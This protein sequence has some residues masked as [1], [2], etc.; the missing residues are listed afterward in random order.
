MTNIEASRLDDHNGP[1]ALPA[2][3]DLAQETDSLSG[4][5]TRRRLIDDIDHRLNSGDVSQGLALILLDLDRFKAANDSLGPMVCDKLLAKISQ[6]LRIG[7]PA[8]GLIARVSGDGFAILLTQ[9]ADADKVAERLLDL[10]GRPYAVGGHVITLGASLGLATSEAGEAATSALELLHAADLAMHQAEEDGRNR[11]RRF[12]PSMKGRAY[13]RHALEADF[14]AAMALQHVELRHALVSQ[15]FEVHFQPQVRLADNHVAGFEAL[16]RWRHPER[17]LVSPE[18]FIPLAEEIGLI[19]LLGDWVLRTACR[20]ATSWEA[21]N[22]G[23]LLRVAVNVSALQLRDRAVFIAGL[24]RA[25]QESGLAAHRLELELT[26]SLFADDIVDTM[27]AIRDLGVELAL[28]DFGTGYSS[29]GRLRRLP[30]DRLK[31]DRSFVLDLDSPETESGLRS[32]EWMVRAIASLGLPTVCEGVE[33]RAQREIVQRAGCTEI[34]GYLVSR[35][36]A[37]LGVATF[38][39]THDPLET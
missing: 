19:D 10:L 38:L 37:A 20:E 24:R 4:L 1:V 15:Q 11:V 9:A 39:E 16:I 21:A 7:A 5:A 28:D 31:I 17:G 8:A 12:D 25:L 22:D 30:F 32:G 14:R 27:R 29:L 3:I 18:A 34:Q 35:P 26:E 2:G 13:G 23:P 36:L 33:T 6:R